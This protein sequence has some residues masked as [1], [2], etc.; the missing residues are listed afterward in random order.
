MPPTPHGQAEGTLHGVFG[1]LLEL[2]HPMAMAMMVEE[3]APLSQRSAHSDGGFSGA[4]GTAVSPIIRKMCIQI[5][6]RET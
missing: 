4:Q 1:L 6:T 3:S 2:Y 5:E